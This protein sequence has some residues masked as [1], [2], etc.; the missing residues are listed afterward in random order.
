MLILGNGLTFLAAVTELNH[1]LSSDKLSERLAHKGVEWKFIPKCALWFG[2][3][4]ERLMGFTKSVL[5][6]TLGQTYATLESLQ[7]ITV[8]IEALMND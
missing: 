4:R 1:L 8:E 3:F 6:K 2:G 7:T 5:K